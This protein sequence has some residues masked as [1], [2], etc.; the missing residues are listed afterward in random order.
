MD[1]QRDRAK[2]DA[3]S[4]QGRPRRRLRLPH[5][6]RRRTAAPSS[7]ATPRSPPR[8]RSSGCSSTASPV[9]AA[10][11][12]RAGRG[13]ARP[14]PV[15]RRGRRPAG[16]HRR[17]ARARRSPSAST[18]CSRRSPGCGC[19]AA[20]SPPARCRSTPPSS[21]RSI[22]AAAAAISRAH[23]A[24]HL[25]HA[26]VRGALGTLGR[27]GRLA[28]RAGPAALRL[29]LALRRR[30][31]GRARRDRGRDQLGP[32]G[33]PRG[34]TYET[35]MDEARKLGA[36]MLFG[37]KY[38]DRVRVVDMGDYSRELCGGTHVGRTGEIGMIKVLSEAS[39]GSGVRRVEAL[40]GLDAFRHVSQ[41]A[42]ARLVARRPAQGQARRSC[43]SGS[44]RWSSGCARRSATWRRC[45]PTPCSPRPARSPPRP[46]TST[47]S[48]WSPCR[49]RTGS[50][51]TTCA[52]SPPTCAPG[53]ARG[54]GVVALFAPA[55]GGKVSF[56]VATTAA[57]RDRGLAAGKLVP[58]FAAAVG[59]RGGG[60][61]DLAQGGGTDP[62]R[63]PGRHRGAARR[64]ARLSGCPEAPAPGRRLGIDVGAVRVGVA[65][66]DPD[67]LLA[68]PLDTVPRDPDGGAD[69]RTVAAL[70]A[71]HEAVGV[72]VGLPRTL[73]GTEGPA[74]V[75]AR[76][77]GDALPA[78]LDVPVEL[79]RRA[80]HH[81]G[82]H[83][84]AAGQRACRPPA[85]GGRR[86]G[87]RRRRS[88][89]A[90]S[91][92]TVRSSGGPVGAPPWWRWLQCAVVRPDGSP[93]RR[94][95]AGRRHG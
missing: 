11:H 69:L 74:A 2:A 65:L 24:T 79:H 16:R 71:E 43:R 92:G 66:S 58:A 54:P 29:H 60:K 27:P 88:C 1:E 90:G 68:T 41:G 13:G 76:A 26:G 35:S 85:A 20:R 82:R 81:R 8:P 44:P 64:A 28:E 14:H 91:T 15:L 37:E 51:A 94:V 55:D 30:G 32:A 36:M 12:R 89:R 40:V 56:V 87:R 39:I 50:A 57:A 78:A 52:R 63:G 10:A 61:P 83:P 4:P 6:A 17:A 18:T 7:S 46:R 33:E 38:G 9:P 34:R 62:C 5:R 75:A 72:V 45:A 67:G 84:P 73:A 23:T 47:A 22:A 95:D 19:T 86:P 80:A 3:P 53:S 70:V 77:F 25:V 93:R 42:R 49:P 59:G 48:R 21:P 31:P